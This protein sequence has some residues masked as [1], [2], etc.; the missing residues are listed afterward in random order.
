MRTK[1][2]SALQQPL[3]FRT[4]LVLGVILLVTIMN[5]L[6]SFLT[7][8]S[9]ENDAVRI[10]LAGSLR[11]QSYRIAESVLLAQ[12]GT[13][14]MGREH[15]LKNEIAEFESR[16]YRPVLVGHIG[17]AGN[18]DL[19]NALSNLNSEWL[20]L[21]SVLEDTEKQLLYRLEE[22]DRFVLLIDDFVGALE[23][24]TENK[25]RLLRILQ[26]VSLLITLIIV[27]IALVD[28]SK[29]VVTPLQKLLAMASRLRSGEFGQ[30]L[31]VTGEDEFSTLSRTFNDM[32]ES[33]EAMY[34][35]LEHKVAEKTLHL[36]KARDDLSILYETSRVL[37]SELPLK[38]R[39]QKSMD[40]L[41]ARHDR[42]KFVVWIKME[43]GS[44]ECYPPNLEIGDIKIDDCVQF[45]VSSETVRYGE[46]L[47]YTGETLP[48]ALCKLFEAVSDNI[49]AAC[50]GETQQVNKRR[51]GLMEERAVIARE[52]HD[53]LAQSLSYLKIQISR[54]HMLKD[55]ASGSEQIEEVIL[56]IK[57]GI[58]D[59][60][61]QLRELLATFRLQ[62][63]DYGLDTSLKSAVDEFSQKGDSEIVL[64]N[65]LENVSLTPNEEIHILQIV[66][67]SLSNVVRHSGASKTDIILS[68]RIDDA[69]EVCIIDNGSGFNNVDT[70][71]N[72]YG[73]IIM[74]ERAKTLSGKIE[75]LNPPGGGAKVCLTFTPECNKSLSSIAVML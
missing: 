44:M 53:S 57:S 18:E 4:S 62:L 17:Q 59:A 3:L 43:D 27:V 12:T 67:E 37:G 58:D 38:E 30:R 23:T 70:S 1:T 29:N 72:H 28:I 51:L 19:Q 48:E 11:M 60:Y 5:I 35:E 10:N 65:H 45:P 61:R 26:L 73:K 21:K 34:R 56:S 8:E 41:K 46:L 52:L 50:K 69:I 55:R 74:R 22:I 15:E 47:V 31:E 66:R 39:I 68:N 25:F 13:V 6:A 9:V 64:T 7:A 40:V 24:Q 32:S 20:Q 2:A 42:F 16:L 54:L 63:T 75:F 36:E 33:L 71:S 14:S 49:A